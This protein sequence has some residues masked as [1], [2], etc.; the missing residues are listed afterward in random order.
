MS[1]NKERPA[2]VVAIPET[3]LRFVKEGF[4]LIPEVE[5]VKSSILFPNKIIEIQPPPDIDDEND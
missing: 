4:A 1:K 2:L 5:Y 3:R